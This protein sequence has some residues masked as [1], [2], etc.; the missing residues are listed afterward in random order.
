MSDSLIIPGWGN[1]EEAKQKYPKH[2]FAVVVEDTYFVGGKY[3]EKRRYPL[4]HV[5][6]VKDHIH[7]SGTFDNSGV[8]YDIV[9]TYKDSGL[10]KTLDAKEKAI[11]RAQERNKTVVERFERRGIEKKRLP[12]GV[13]Y[14]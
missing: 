10:S 14:V 4:Y 7:G 9:E 13:A 1:P 8:L 2:S 3:I 11:V 12:R 6:Y 5:V